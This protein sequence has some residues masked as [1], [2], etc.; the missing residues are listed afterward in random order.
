MHFYF[1]DTCYWIYLFVS[2]NYVYEKTE[3][4]YPSYGQ[5]VPQLNSTQSSN[6]SHIKYIL[7]VRDPGNVASETI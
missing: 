1:L 3:S 6:V 7:L 2:T 4:P 5:K